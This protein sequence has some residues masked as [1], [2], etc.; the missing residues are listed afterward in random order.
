[1]QIS[2]NIEVATNIN[3]ENECTHTI[4]QEKKFTKIA[5]NDTVKIGTNMLEKVRAGVNNKQKL[6]QIGATIGF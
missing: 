2:Q 4:L 5:Q 1:M 3:N 6:G